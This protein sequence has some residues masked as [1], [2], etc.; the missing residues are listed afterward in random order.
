MTQR[1][2]EE[3][4]GAPGSEHAGRTRQALRFVM[5]LGVVS[6]FADMAYEGARSIAGPYL[7]MLGASATIVG[8]TAGL[9]ELLGYALRIVSGY[10]SDRT[11]RYWAVTIVGY[12]VNLV[13]VPLLALVGHWEL[14]VLLLMAERI[15]KA[16][17][18]PARDA[19]LSYATSQIG[20]GWGFGIHEALDQAGAVLGPLL[21]VGAMWAGNG[22]RSG[23]AVLAVPALC[24]LT[25]LIVV[26]SWHPRPGA[27]E[28]SAPLVTHGWPKSYWIY[29]AGSAL[30]AAGFTDF[31][32]IAYHFEQAAV[33]HDPLIPVYYAVAMGVDAV[34]ALVLGR[35]FDQIG[36]PVIAGAVALAAPF[37]PLIFYGGP[38]AALLGI[39]LWGVGLASQ[40]SVMRAAVAELI[41]TQRRAAAYGVFNAGYGAAWFA[42]SALMGALYD[43]SLGALVGFA[44]V[45][46]IAAI[47]VLLAVGRRQSPGAPDEVASSGA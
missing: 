31:A 36:Y 10:I 19:M 11:A 1:V 2:L 43:R 16:I 13:A 21:V 4:H 32:I 15:G 24:A 14:A 30:V 28:A 7:A 44:V 40:E 22:Y 5:L 45:T 25:V 37:A 46:Q 42:G 38:G 39:S 35:L 34:A 27:F 8:I 9:G 23:F 29:L 17:R 18:T 12:T 20:R 33:M 3:P 6:L 41:P 47:P 26:R